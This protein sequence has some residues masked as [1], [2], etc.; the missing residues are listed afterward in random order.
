MKTHSASQSLAATIR[1][2]PD[3]PK[4]GILF[5]DITTLLQDPRAFKKTVDILVKEYKGK[6]ID[7][8]VAVESRGFI[9][10]AAL[11]YKLGAA[12]IP[13]R[14]KGKLPYKT[15]SVTYALE[16]GTD[17]LEM[18]VDGLKKDARVLI[19]D[20]L[21]ATGGTVQAVAKLVKG[22][23]ARI[24]GMA[25]VVELGFLKGRRKLKGVPVYSVITF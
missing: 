18:H 13:V 17:T 12:F 21:L 9:F 24:V 3:F 19:V 25:F 1:D 15:Q 6:E 2:V 11:A 16:Y 4:P 7:A 5:K 20:D 10:G 14:K 22:F 8:V 23:K